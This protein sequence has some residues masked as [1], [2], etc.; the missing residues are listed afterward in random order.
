MQARFSLTVVLYFVAVPAFAD[1]G[2]QV[3]LDWPQIIAFAAH[4]TNYSGTYVYQHDGH[5]ESAR[6]THISD[7]SGE[8][9]KLESMDGPRRAFI[10][11]NNEVQWYSGDKNAVKVERQYSS[12]RFPAL[13]PELLSALNENYLI[14]TAE[15]ARISG[16][17]TQA[18]VFQPKDSLRYT[19]KMWAHMDS[20]L[21]LKAA[22]LDERQ[23]IVEQYT[24]IELK[25]G[26]KIERTQVMLG[27]SDGSLEQQSHSATPPETSEQF[28]TSE[29]K[30]AAVP[31][32]FKKIMEKRRL[33]HGK[34]TNVIHIVFSDGLAGISV[35]IETSV[36]NFKKRLGLSSRGAIHVYRKIKDDYL[37][38]VV[39]EVPPRTVI[40][41]ADSVRQ[42]VH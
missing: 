11:N 12:K 28:E 6:I 4:Q 42:N 3:D 20:G 18:I 2:R 1:I 16:F 14:Q 19:Q 36:N 27:Q 32:G 8:H 41:V 29:W 25:I 35:F 15:Q 34:K 30:V 17:D 37:V 39:G 26:G 33:L 9:E 5:M 22:V 40:Q 13:Q 38:T 7:Q 10:R 21:L 31:T 24:F 23:E